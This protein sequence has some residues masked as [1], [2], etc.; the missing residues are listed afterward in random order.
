MVIDRYYKW[1]NEKRTHGSLNRQDP[2]NA[3][4]KYNPTPFENEKLLNYLQKTVQFISGRYS[5]VE[6]VEFT[7]TIEG[8]KVKVVKPK[9]VTLLRVI[10]VEDH[11]SLTNLNSKSALRTLQNLSVHLLR[12]LNTTIRKQ[13]IRLQTVM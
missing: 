5:I 1:Y 11:L 4:K 12:I 7:E 8:K 2:E 10:R 3:W 9:N 13:L 6:P